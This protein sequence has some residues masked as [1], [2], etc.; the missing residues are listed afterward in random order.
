MCFIYDKSYKISFDFKKIKSL[1][2]IKQKTIDTF[3][4]GIYIVVTIR[5]RFRAE[6]LERPIRDDK[7]VSFFH[8]NNRI[9]FID[10]Y[11]RVQRGRGA[12]LHDK[13][14]SIKH[15]RSRVL[16]FEP[17]P[18]VGRI[19][20]DFQCRRRLRLNG[21]GLQIRQGQLQRKEKKK[22]I[23]TSWQLLRRTAT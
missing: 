8:R 9:H 1:R 12:T 10:P 21:D 16:P 20:Q 7:K 22:W 4:F 11:L 19:R 5:N 23:S 18:V 3:S 13:Y 14:P 15:P 17:G 6:I 2:K